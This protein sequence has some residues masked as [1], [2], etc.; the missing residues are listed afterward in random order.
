MTEEYSASNK[1]DFVD[2]L[3]VASMRDNEWSINGE[4]DDWVPE[5][6]DSDEV[7]P[8]DDWVEGV[9]R[10]RNNCPF[11]QMT[12]DRA[13]YNDEGEEQHYVLWRCAGCSFWQWYFLE[14]MGR[15]GGVWCDAAAP[16]E[17]TFEDSLPDDCRSEWARHLSRNPKLWTG[18]SSTKLETFVADIFRA[19]YAHA[20]VIHVGRPADRGIDIVFIESNGKKWIVQVKGRT[21]PNA[22]EG[23]ETLQKL[24]GTLFLEGCPNGMIVTTADHFS[25]HVREQVGRASELGV[26]VELIDQG[27]LTRMLGPMLP[28]SR[29]KVGIKKWFEDAPELG[30]TVEE[31]LDAQLPPI[32]QLKLRF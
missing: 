7:S 22:T 27:K 4:P 28:I 17:Q 23:F 5:D 19:N 20:D 21:R 9:F 16:F 11:C 18:I 6:N 30:I 29:W 3:D 13:E 31:H 2:L 32:E 14:Y 8:I 10:K 12:F 24:L 15:A 1:Y 25:Y 26:R